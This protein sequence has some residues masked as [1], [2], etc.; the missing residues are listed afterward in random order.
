VVDMGQTMQRMK[1]LNKTTITF[2]LNTE[3]K[4]EIKTFC[5]KENMTIT[6]L[7]KDAVIDYMRKINKKKEIVFQENTGKLEVIPKNN[8][9]EDFFSDNEDIF[10]A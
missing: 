1:E 8:F 4:K 6:K 2:C 5:A 10:S 3:F 7:I 9:D